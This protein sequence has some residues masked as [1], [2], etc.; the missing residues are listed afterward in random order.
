MMTQW[1][2]KRASLSVIPPTPACR[3]VTSHGEHSVPRALCRAV[4]VPP[5]AVTVYGIRCKVLALLEFGILRHR[6]TAHRPGDS[7]QQAELL[8]GTVSKWTRM[9]GSHP[10]GEMGNKTKMFQKLL[11]QPF[12]LISSSVLGTR[13]RILGCC[14]CI[15]KIR[16][17]WFYTALLAL[18]TAGRGR[19]RA[20]HGSNVNARCQRCNAI[21]RK[22]ISLIQNWPR[23]VNVQ[24]T[25]P[26]DIS[27]G[28]LRPGC[29]LRL[30]NVVFEPV[31][32]NQQHRSSTDGD[33]GG[34]VQGECG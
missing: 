8:E 5:G 21:A 7:L 23:F 18:C 12:V 33:C 31:F 26:E 22:V 9:V 1:P 32:E 2:S 6:S 4:S 11:E 30:Q 15:N 17:W 25:A 10:T 14:A 16:R 27:K 20:D 19:S 24:K 34:L 13:G 28:K 29:H 3:S